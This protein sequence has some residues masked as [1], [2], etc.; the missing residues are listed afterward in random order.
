M[1]FERRAYTLGRSA[2]PMNG[3]AAG[4]AVRPDLFRPSRRT[5]RPQ[6]ANQ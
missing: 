3:I 5:V 2:I 6:E 1:L 4:F